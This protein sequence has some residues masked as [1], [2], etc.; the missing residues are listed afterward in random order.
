MEPPKKRI[1]LFIDADNAPAAKIDTILS[2]LAKYGAVNIRKAYGNWKSSHVKSWE[3]ILHEHAIQPVQQFDLTK[4]KNATDMAMV[5]EAMDVLYT[6]NVDVFSIVSSDCDFTPLVMRLRAE[7]SDVVGF[8][9][10]KTPAAF[11]NACSSFLYLDEER[12]SR[13]G[14]TAAAR[15]SSATL[16]Q[17]TR[18]INLIRNAIEATQDE[19][20]GAFLGR[21]GSH[22]SNQASFDPRN[23]GYGKL[24]ELIKAIDL[25][26]IEKRDDS[27]LY[28]RD[29]RRALRAP[30]AAEQG[31]AKTSAKKVAKK[32][33]KKTGKRTAKKD[34]Q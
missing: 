4:G 8:G 16:K 25:F 14:G 1:A 5:I 15:K 33:G 30:H 28:V 9:Q 10:R 20:G 27:R 12:S 13:E 6:K 2:E 22:I 24:S 34:K 26:E 17:D 29:A 21:I 31:S 23:Y 18:L 32:T 11:V 3:A 7:G 19:E